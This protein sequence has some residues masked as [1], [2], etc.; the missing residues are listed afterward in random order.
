MQR[1]NIKQQQQTERRRGAT[2]VETA[3]I[4]PVFFLV[5]FAIIEFGHVYLVIHSLN[6]AAKKASRDAAVLGVSN[7]EVVQYI[8]GQLQGVL[9]LSKT[10]VLIKDASSYDDQ[11]VDVSTLRDEDF[12]DIDLASAQSRQLFLIRVEVDYDTVSII[13]S[14]WRHVLGRTINGRS[15]M[16]HE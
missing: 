8:N 1:Q 15:I 10:R 6:S 14:F 13:P 4:L 9:D 5:L 7:D 16:R 12:P 11:D 2:L 3:V